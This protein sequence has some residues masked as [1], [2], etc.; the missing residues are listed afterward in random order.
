MPWIIYCFL[1]VWFGQ[2][3]FSLTQILLSLKN[4]QQISTKV[5]SNSKNCIVPINQKEVNHKNDKIKAEIE[6][7]VLKNPEIAVSKSPKIS[8]AIVRQSFLFKDY[9]KQANPFK[10]SKVSISRRM[11]GSKSNPTSRS[12][13]PPL[14]E[15]AS[16]STQ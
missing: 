12:K 15:T 8:K 1:G 14:I 11:D 3:L 6:I 2:I 10:T 4:L 5:S 9:L 16:P 7:Y 13:V